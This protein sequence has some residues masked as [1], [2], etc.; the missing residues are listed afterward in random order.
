MDVNSIYSDQMIRAWRTS[1]EEFKEQC[2]KPTVK[3]TGGSVMVLVYFSSSSTGKLVFIEC[4][5]R[6]EDYLEI[7]KNSILESAVMLGL[8]DRLFVSKIM[9]RR[10]QHG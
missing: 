2:V 9:I 4:I 6:K 7:L 8:E 10:I 3:H 1:T 5:M